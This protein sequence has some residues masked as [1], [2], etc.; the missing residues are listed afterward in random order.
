MP[1]GKSEE[2][3]QFDRQIEFEREK[4]NKETTADD[5]TYLYDQEKKS[6]LL[7]WQQELGDELI[8]CVQ[9]LRG[10]AMNEN[11]IWIKV[12]KEPL[13]NDKFIYDIVMPQCKPFL[14]RNLINS[15][16]DE[17]RIL[18]MLRFTMD[19]VTNVM[20]E[21]HDV[22]DIDFRDFDVIDMLITNVIMP[23]PFRALGGWTKRTDST[24]SKRIEAFQETT[25]PQQKRGLMAGIFGG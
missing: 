20:A 7:R 11:G 3:K 2:D 16:L 23:A 8:E 9:T 5:Q 15:N 13:C 25:Q 14:S 21:G 18:K 1:K 12:R 10:F 19:T 17:K 22:Y 4:I 24:M 6:D